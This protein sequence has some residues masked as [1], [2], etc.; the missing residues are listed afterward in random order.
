MKE[1]MW[2]AAFDKCRTGHFENFLKEHKVQPHLE[3]FVPH[4]NESARPGV[5]IWFWFGEVGQQFADSW[6][7][8]W[9]FTVHHFP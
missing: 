6:S 7:P 3:L 1:G 4:Q 8:L 9:L 2:D 5:S